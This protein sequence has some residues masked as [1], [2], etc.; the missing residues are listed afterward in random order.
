MRAYSFGRAFSAEGDGEEV[1]REV[2]AVGEVGHGEGSG[3]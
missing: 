2:A 3:L 1:V